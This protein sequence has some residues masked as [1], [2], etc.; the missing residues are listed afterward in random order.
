MTCRSLMSLMQFFLNDTS[1]QKPIFKCQTFFLFIYLFITCHQSN[2]VSPR[3]Y[4]YCRISNIYRLSAI[5]NSTALPYQNSYKILYSAYCKQQVLLKLLDFLFLTSLVQ[6]SS[7]MKVAKNKFVNIKNRLV[8]FYFY[9][10]SSVKFCCNFIDTKLPY[11]LIC[12]A[13]SFS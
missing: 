12:A 11:C 3:R 6:F 1:C 4:K 13:A 5:I 8:D 2:F 10:L 9:C 7:M